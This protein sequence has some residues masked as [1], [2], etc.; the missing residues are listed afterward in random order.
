M[1]KFALISNQ[2][3]IGKVKVYNLVIDDIDQ[4]ESYEDT[5]EEIYIP[6]FRSFA[7]TIAQISENKKPPPHGKRRKICGV[8]H[9]AEMR[10][11]DLRLYYL[12][13]YDHGITICLGGLKP[14]Q[15]KNIRY[16][17]SLQKEI[18]T[19][20]KENGKLEIKQPKKTD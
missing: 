2:F 17:K 10:T 14:G 5:L 8:E 4:F 1:S 15:I 19:Y 11:K 18:L 7:A 6:Q 16:L 9:A 12:V 3:A 13:L 20:I